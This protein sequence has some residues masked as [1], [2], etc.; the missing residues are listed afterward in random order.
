MQNMISKEN[1][2]QESL[3]VWCLCRPKTPVSD[4]GLDF[5][6]AAAAAALSLTFEPF[7]KIVKLASW[8]TAQ[9]LFSVLFYFLRSEERQSDG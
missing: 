6:I 2:A 3:A 4:T 7:V 8:S 9:V 5:T 1:R